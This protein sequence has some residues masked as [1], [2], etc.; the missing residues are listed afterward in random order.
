M[1]GDCP[2]S[3]ITQLASPR[4]QF[5]KRCSLQFRVQ[6][7]RMARRR[8]QQCA[9]RQYQTTQNMWCHAQVPCVLRRI[10][11]ILRINDCFLTRKSFAARMAV[12]EYVCYLRT[13]D[14]RV[15]KMFRYPAFATKRLLMHRDVPP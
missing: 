11:L 3:R 14:G 8:C 10:G 5:R 12:S 6:K 9:Y 7:L 2:A 1:K 15:S 13:K 4:D